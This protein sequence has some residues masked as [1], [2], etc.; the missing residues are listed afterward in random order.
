MIEWRLKEVLLENGIQ[1]ASQFKLA[2]E[3]TV[4]ID[5]S[6]V[7]L[8]KLFTREPAAL[9]LQTAQFIC[10]LFQI[11]LDH[12]LKVSPESS[13]STT[14]PTGSIIQPYGCKRQCESPMIVDP[15]SFF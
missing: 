7:A 12:F 6:R 2:L 14:Q 11:S 5:I 15:R 3:E 9:R 13:N 4:G 8:N 10:T 1:N